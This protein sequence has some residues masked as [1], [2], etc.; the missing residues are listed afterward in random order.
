MNKLTLM[1]ALAFC[2]GTSQAAP[3]QKCV[4]DKGRVYYGD[5]IPPEV[6]DKCRS[7]SEMTK[8]GLEKKQTRYLTEEEKKAQADAA[9]AKKAEEQKAEEQK[10]RD[11]ALLETYSEEKEIDRTRDRN[12]QATQAQIDSTQT[13]IKSV[14]GRLDAL[15]KQADGFVKRNK[16]VPPDLNED[17]RRA[18]DEI[19]KTNETLAKWKHEYEDIK[20][21]SDED[22]K[23][24]RELK[25]IPHPQPSPAPAK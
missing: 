3:L 20:V 21:R 16:P 25:G 24:F 9:A 23:R 22:K 1:M 14:Q 7:S 18:E 2:A 13:R 10:R 4:D 17:I 11:R 8:R 6:L 15:N 12:L 19:K 5:A